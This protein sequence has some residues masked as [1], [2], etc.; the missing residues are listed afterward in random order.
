MHPE[1]STADPSAADPASQSSTARKTHR[2]RPPTRPRRRQ[3]PRN[4]RPRRR[5]LRPARSG[6]ATS[7]A[8]STPSAAKPSETPSSM[9][10]S[11]AP[12]PTPSSAHCEP[13]S[14][15]SAP[16]GGP[17]PGC[18]NAPSPTASPAPSRRVR[19]S[20]GP[21][22]LERSP[23]RH[24]QRDLRPFQ[25]RPNRKTP[26]RHVRILHSLPPA[27]VAARARSLRRAMKFFDDKNTTPQPFSDFGIAMPDFDT[28]MNASRT[29]RS[30]AQPTTG[31]AG[32]RHSLPPHGP[33][34]QRCRTLLKQCA[35][36]CKSPEQPNAPPSPM[37]RP[38]NHNNQPSSDPTN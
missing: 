37:R 6:H 8:T 25:I 21:R 29:K 19:R 7:A 16:T 26:P 24:Q 3:T 5:R 9:S 35:R 10:S 31:T 34:G 27:I 11:A 2:P 36:A 33:A 22:T 13:C 15:P 12:K 18:S 38:A 17:P 30:R 1:S 4:L 32:D 20:P 23:Q 28:L 14:T